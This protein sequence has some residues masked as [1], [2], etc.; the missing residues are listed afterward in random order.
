MSVKM[1]TLASAKNM[2]TNYKLR[3]KAPILALILSLIVVFITLAHG[4]DD[5]HAKVNSGAGSVEA[6]EL[7]SGVDHQAAPSAHGILRPAAACSGGT[8]PAVEGITLTGCYQ[9]NFTVGGNPRIIRVWYTTDTSTYTVGRRA[10]K[11]GS[12]LCPQRHRWPY[13]PRAVH[14]WLQF[15][16]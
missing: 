9:R 3:I 14:Q 6:A 10:R 8:A 2:R 7:S 1:I 15:G 12:C 11:L 16:P 13:S 4:P 5:K